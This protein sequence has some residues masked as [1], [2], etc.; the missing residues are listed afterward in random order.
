VAQYHEQTDLDAKEG[1]HGQ[2]VRY[3]T[4]ADPDYGFWSKQHN[5][6]FGYFA[7][8]MNP[9]DLEVMLDRMNLE[10]LAALHL[11]ER[12]EAR[13]L[14]LGCG[15]GTTARCIASQRPDTS[16][17]GIT[18]VPWQARR[19]RELTHEHGSA[20]SGSADIIPAD[21]VLADFTRTPFRDDTFDGAYALESSCYAPGLDK[22]PLIREAYRVIKPGGRLVIADAFLKTARPMNAVTR[23]CY[24]A[25]C[26]CWA[27]ETWGDVHCV[28]E[29]LVASGFRD[30][31]IVNI[32]RNVTPSVLHIPT[33]TLKFAVTELLL[34]RSALAAPRVGH[35]LAGLLLML[36]A[37]DRT[38]SGYFLLSATK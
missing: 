25:L 21:F 20:A 18:V 15:V 27:L 34:R 14:D 7:R 19:A 3:Y 17:A 23:A 1:R 26:R 35:M 31:R 13:L 4:Q 11:P 5:M 8:G 29:C 38:R 24:G 28:T 22:E 10:V 9:F 30:L 2:I 33:V 6:H 37:L 16:V 12:G 32:S 36:F